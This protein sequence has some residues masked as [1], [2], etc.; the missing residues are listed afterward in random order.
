MGKNTKPDVSQIAFITNQKT[1]IAACDYLQPPD[2]NGDPDKCPASL[3]ARYSRI[4]LI[5]TDFESNPSVFLTYN[6]DP[7]EIRLLHEKIGML[8]MTERNFD[9]STTK[10]FSSFGNNWMEVFRIT[11]MP[12]RNNQ[13]AKYPW[14]ISIRAGT[15]E[16]GKFKAEQEV[17][18]FL[19]DDEIQKFFID[20]VAYLNVWEMTHGAPFI[21]NVIEPY[22]A[23]R[24][25]GILEKSRKAAE[26]SS[27]DD[28]EIYDFD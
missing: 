12:M 14:A 24:R 23:E 21:R 7:S 25:K 3:H 8:T 17:R 27:P 4:K 6:L 15:S 19:S 16:N 28:F 26:L 11:R 2:L 10:D 18:K 13:K 1:L 22:K 9:W 20:I 5:L